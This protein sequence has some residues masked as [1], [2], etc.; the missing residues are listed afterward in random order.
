[1]IDF[2]PLD[3]GIEIVTASRGMSKGIAQTD[4]PQLIVRPS[5]SL[6]P[7]QFAAQWKNLSSPV[8]GGEAAFSVG[9][10]PKLAG[11][12][13]GL[14][15]AHKVQ[16]GVREPTDDHSWEFSGTVSRKFGRFSL[17]AQAIYSPDDLGGARRSLYVEGGPIFEINSTTRLGANI[18]HRDRVDGDDYTSFN[19]GIAKT[20]FKGVTAE[21]RYYDTN[22]SELDTPY[23]GRAVAS[24]RMAF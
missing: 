15:A 13:L 3:P 20:L 17:R 10:S 1:M 16:T 12:Q 5:V 19:A 7:V 14:S 18:G 2:P 22:R 4:G 23:E 21:L 11:F 9:V 24:V 8:A 6:G